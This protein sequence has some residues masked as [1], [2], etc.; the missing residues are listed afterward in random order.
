MCAFVVWEVFVSPITAVSE[1]MA[2]VFKVC[3][4]IQHVAPIE[5]SER[6]YISTTLYVKV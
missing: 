6:D 3:F 5:D 4:N 2:E 1:R